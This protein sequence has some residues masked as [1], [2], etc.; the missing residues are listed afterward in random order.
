M[1]AG[2]PVSG[3]WIRLLVAVNSYPRSNFYWRDS[4]EFA[5]GVYFDAR[6][7]GAL[8]LTESSGIILQFGGYDADTGILPATADVWGTPHLDIPAVYLFPSPLRSF[9]IYFHLFLP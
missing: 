1:C 7:M 6:G 8:F 4:H 2:R 3:S 9:L 5:W